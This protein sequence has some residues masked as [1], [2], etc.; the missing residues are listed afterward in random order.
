MKRDFKAKLD[1]LGVAIVY[2]YGSRATGR[3]SPLSDMDIGIVLKHPSSEADQRTLYH[4]F[5]QLFSEVYPRAKLDIVFLQTAP[6]SLQFSAI[7]EGKIMFQEDPRRTAD[8]EQG[9]INQY[10]DFRTVLDLFDRVTLE[11]YG[12]GESPT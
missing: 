11:G 10:L 9:V 1:R 6:L 12:K 3:A 2:L 8:Y 7:R 5:Y 4:M